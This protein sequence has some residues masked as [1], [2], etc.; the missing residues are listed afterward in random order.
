MVITSP[1]GLFSVTLSMALI[2]MAILI[3]VGIVITATLRPH[4]RSQQNAL[5]WTMAISTE[6]MIPLVPSIE[7]F[8]RESGG[9]MAEKARILAK[10][11]ASGVPLPDAVEQIPGILPERILPMIRVGYESGALAKSLRQAVL[12][13]DLLTV[14]W[15][16]LITK[17]LYIGM[18]IIIGTGI[19]A[20][21]MIKIVPSYEKIFRDFHTSLPGITAA[22]I[23]VSRFIGQTWIIFVPLYL[24][25]VGLFIY[26]IFYYLGWAS[27]SLPGFTRLMRRK[28]SAIILDSL[29]L[30]AESSQP[31]GNIVLTMA[32]T[33]PQADIRRKLSYVGED[34]HRGGDW[35]ESLSRHGLI[36]RADQAVLKAA[37]RVGNLPWA[38]REMADSNRRRLAYRLNALV[39]AAYPPVIICVGLIVMFI[40]VAL[41]YPLITLIMKLSGV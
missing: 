28:H 36:K 4:Y 14:I 33:Y 39:Q 34:I 24:L 40:V 23:E 10:L 5:L 19:F 16:S 2:I 30:A 29:A 3:P 6:K 15:N 11:L 41:F 31:L 13:R 18:V 38:M 26:L 27:F 9:R 25:F 21:V 7:A 1:S 17:L 35:C 22:L 12:S 37:Q 32:G 8:S 20:F